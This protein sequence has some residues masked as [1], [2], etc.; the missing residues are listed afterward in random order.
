M[1]PIE[2][3]L[4]GKEV[5]TTEKTSIKEVTK[6]LVNYVLDPFDEDEWVNKI[7]I[8]NNGRNF[9]YDINDYRVEQVANK[10]VEV[11]KEVYKKSR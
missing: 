10:Y 1:P 6:G 7:K 5:I 3:M 9:N 8:C 11:F 2:A 4:L